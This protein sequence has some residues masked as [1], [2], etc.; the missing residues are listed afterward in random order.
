MTA[1]IAQRRRS[2]AQEENMVEDSASVSDVD[3]V[4]PPAEKASTALASAAPHR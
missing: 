3:G 1:L 2:S 4:G